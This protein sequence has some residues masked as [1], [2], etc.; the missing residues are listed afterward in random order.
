MYKSLL[1]EIL[2]E[3]GWKVV[4]TVVHVYVTRSAKVSATFTDEDML[5]RYNYVTYL[6]INC[7][8]ISRRHINR[9][10]CTKWHTELK[11]YVF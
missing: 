2:N 10:R 1:E 11:M 4:L 3:P 7:W 5:G 6:F 9:A 8:S